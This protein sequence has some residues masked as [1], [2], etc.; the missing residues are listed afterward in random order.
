[1]GL[2]GLMSTPSPDG[3]SGFNGGKSRNFKVSTYN[4]GKTTSIFSGRRRLRAWPNISGSSIEDPVDKTKKIIDT[5]GYSDVY[6]EG[7]DK[8]TD[9]SVSSKKEGARGSNLLHNNDVYDTSV[10]NILEKLSGTKAQ[11][12][13]TDFAY[14]KD[15]GVY[16]NNRLMIARRFHSPSGDNIMVKAKEIGS[17]ATLMSWIP[18]NDNFLEITFGEKWEEAK[19][20]FTG[21]LNSLGEDFSKKGLGGIAGAAANVLPLPG[22]TEIFQRQ[23]LAKLGLLEDSAASSIPAGNPNLIKEAK[24]RKTVGYSEAGSG[25]TA[26]ISVKMICEYEMKFISGID[27]TIVWMDLIGVMLRFGTSDSS[28]YGLSQK[29]AAKLARWASNPYS[30]IDDIVTGIEQAVKKAYDKMV[31]I[32]GKI[33]D[34]A[35]E[36]AQKLSDGTEDT[37]G[38]QTSERELAVQA[39]QEAKDAGVKILDGLKK[40]GRD[41]IAASVMKYR[42]EVMG[43]VN[44]LTGNPSTPWHLTVG[45]PLRPVF[46]SG[47]MYTTDVTIKLGPIL[48]FNDLPSTITCEF[49][50]QNARNLGLQEILAKFNSGYLRTVDTQ[51]TFLE[52]TILMSGKNVTGQEAPGGLVGDLGSFTQTEAPVTPLGSGGSGGTGGTSGDLNQGGG[53]TQNG[54]TGST[55]T[56]GTGGT[57]G[58]GGGTGGTGGTGGVPGSTKEGTTIAS[59][60]QSKTEGGQAQTKP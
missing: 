6:S 47:D 23:F 29:V 59:D 27:P 44:A 45:N 53:N 13:P 43:I 46:C 57:G 19:A 58:L 35:T 31:E 34:A 25:L 33:Y 48:A 50:L 55:G 15:L 60:K 17:I 32:L 26:K 49:T 52:T 16:P 42:V 41:A 10:L 8:Y 7:K 12:K 18:E 5:T 56:G 4:T 14:L 54:Q 3:M 20:D 1:M 38:K 22:F 36:A 11:L 40:L 2:I 37:S 30:L 9:N 21:M 51:R 24:V 28:N 39:A